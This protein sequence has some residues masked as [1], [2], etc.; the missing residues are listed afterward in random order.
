MESLKLT[1]PKGYV[2]MRDAK[3]VAPELGNCA[4][5]RVKVYV[6]HRLKCLSVL[7]VK[8]NLLYCHAHSIDLAYAEFRVQEAGRQRVLRDKRNNVHA[9]VVGHFMDIDA[10]RNVVSVK[11]GWRPASYDPYKYGFFYD[12][13]TEQPVMESERLV[14]YDSPPTGSKS[15]GNIWYVPK[16]RSVGK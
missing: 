3:S 12:D 13:A 6:N 11:D 15:Y 10:R 8:T 9:Y 16:N 5:D 4:P 1:E 7:N 14:I 2:H